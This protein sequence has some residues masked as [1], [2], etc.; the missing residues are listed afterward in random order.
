[1]PRYF[2]TL[3]SAAVYQFDDF[4][5]EIVLTFGRNEIANYQNGLSTCTTVQFTAAAIHVGHH[6]RSAR[7]SPGAKL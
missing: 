6:A 3:F 2:S 5:R 7:G 1:M 4:L